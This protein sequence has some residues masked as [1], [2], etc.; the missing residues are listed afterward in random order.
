MVYSIFSFDL[1]LFTQCY[2][3]TA[4]WY[5]VYRNYPEDPA[6]GGDAKC[7]RVGQTG[8]LENDR[9]PIFFSYSPNVNR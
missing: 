9:V 1:C 4:T 5:L 6:M 2:P 8:P 3:L 7:V